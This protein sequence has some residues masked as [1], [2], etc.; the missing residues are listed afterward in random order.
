[1]AAAHRDVIAV[2]GW[3]AL[4]PRAGLVRVGLELAVSAPP[5][6]LYELARQAV[7]DSSGLPAD[8]IGPEAAEALQKLALTLEA[9]TPKM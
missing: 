9:S 8:E 5:G 7:E 6:A 3:D 4:H 2:D 1:M